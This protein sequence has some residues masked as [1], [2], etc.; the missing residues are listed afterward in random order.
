MRSSFMFEQTFGT[1]Y[2]VC[3][4]PKAQELSGLMRYG[5]TRIAQTRKNVQVP[6][7]RKI[8]TKAE[9]AVVWLG[10]ENFNSGTAIDHD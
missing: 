1:H 2:V 5:S 10:E 9:R 3:D 8:Y 4:N 7:M 6:L